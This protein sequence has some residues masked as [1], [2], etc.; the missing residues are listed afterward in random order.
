MTWMTP[1]RPA[2]VRHCV[3]TLIVLV[4][5]VARVALLGS[6]GA[7]IPYVTFFPAVMLA[8]LYGGF[9]SGLLATV[10]SV[11]V[12]FWIQCGGVA[13]R[14][15]AYDWSGMA[16]FVATA[17]MTCWVAEALHRARLRAAEADSL[18]RLVAERESAIEALRESRALLSSVIESLPF[19][20]WA[21]T[22]ENRYFLLNSLSKQIWGD[23][24]GKSPGEVGA[25]PETVGLWLENNVRALTGELVRKEVSHDQN[26]QPRTF[27]SIIGPVRDGSRILG[28]FGVNIDIT[29][30]KLVEETLRKKEEDLARAQAITHLGS[31][32][33]NV[34]T[35]EVDWSDETYQIFGVRPDTIDLSPEAIANLIHFEDLPTQQQWLADAVAGKHLAPFDCRI[36]RPGGEVRCVRVFGRETPRELADGPLT[37]YG[38]ILD[39][40]DVWKTGE[41]L[42]RSESFLNEI[43]KL[44]KV[45][46]WEHDLT[47]REA[48]WTRE[49]YD[50][51]ELE[52]DTP[53]GPDKHLDYYHPEDRGVLAN[54][55][56]H[57]VIMGDPFDL[58]LRG[59]T[60][61]RRPIWVRVIGRPV[62]QDG[63]CVKIYGSLQDISDRKRSEERLRLA[64]E[65]AQDASR[66]KSEFLANMSH[67]I[68]TPL[69]AILGLTELCQ[70]VSSPERIS[71]NL[72]MI[73]SSARSLLGIVGDV[74]DL[75]RVEAGKLEIDH[76]PFNLRQVMEN[77]LATNSLALSEKKLSLALEMPGDIP[78]FLLGDPLR[79][80]QV[81]SNLVGN[82]AKFTGQGGITLSVAVS[83][84]PA[85]DE[86]EL[87]F[88]VKDTGIGIPPGMLDVIFESFRQADSTFSKPYQGVGLGLAICRELTAL[89]GGVIWVESTQGIG[90]TFHFTAVFGLASSTAEEASQA[91]ARG[92]TV[93]LRLLVAEDNLMNRRVYEEFLESLGHRVTTASDGQEALRCLCQ[94]PFDLALMDVQM[95]V[96][97]GVEVVRRL[98]AGEC[99]PAAAAMPVVALTAY[100]MAGDQERFLQAGMTGYLA[101][102]VSLSVLEKAVMEFAARPVPARPARSV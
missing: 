70:H 77:A 3:A 17:V 20:F 85:Q 24:T 86:V 39:V 57:A 76:K 55:L 25:P 71:V 100:A 26:G 61:K 10:L 94:S 79:L 52:G 16:L 9:T 36:V 51:I 58:E 29:E 96:I 46:G 35:N 50:I 42:A 59:F 13:S 72:E 12:S 69:S 4:A 2:W 95:P 40:T 82:A 23:V 1:A 32:S 83:G 91:P 48:K 14:L 78:P 5:A 81:L 7:R 92:E 19:Q 66:A 67:E 88:Q 80:G 6:L 89:M 47:T 93:S 18:G 44:S 11:A 98:R 8:S 43:G 21:V 101:K 99:G 49:L 28:A 22:P 15:D 27:D 97:D 102:P 74:L 53:P 34:E 84:K 68:R 45:G 60:M 31:W 75:S 54:A 62:F 65:R 63:Q 33:W 73:A 90:S 30:R 37:V 87:H 64:N 41:A 38:A 56:E